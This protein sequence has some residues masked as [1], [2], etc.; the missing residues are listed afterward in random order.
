MCYIKDT[1]PQPVYEAAFLALWP[2][3]WTLP[4]RDISSPVVLA[5]VLSS[6]NVSGQGNPA[7][8]G[9]EMEAII[10][11]VQTVPVKER[12]SASTQKALE[13]GAFGAPWAWV[14][15]ARGEE[16]PFFGSDRF[17]YMWQ[18]LGIPFQD[19]EVLPRL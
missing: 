17:P 3:M 4:H 15:N 10:H 13:L 11:S 7:F 5:A 8:S 9:T 12:L 6:V 18:F 14:R 19:I 16:Q 2:A 1:F